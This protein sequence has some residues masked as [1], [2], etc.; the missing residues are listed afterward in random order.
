MLDVGIA[1]IGLNRGH[2]VMLVVVRIGTDPK[3]SGRRKRARAE[4]RL[5]KCG[6]VRTKNRSFPTTARS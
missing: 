2:I 5:L 3:D 4:L 1:K 6:R